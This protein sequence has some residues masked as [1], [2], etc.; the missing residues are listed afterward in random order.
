MN[1]TPIEYIVKKHEGM[2]HVLQ[3]EAD[4]RYYQYHEDE[5]WLKLPSNQGAFFFHGI[6]SMGKAMQ[7]IDAITR[8]ARFETGGVQ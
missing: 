7:A 8:H 6:K 5:K 2:A 3:I 1:T 4:G